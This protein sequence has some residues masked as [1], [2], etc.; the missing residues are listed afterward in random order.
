M[1]FET[2]RLLTLLMGVYTL[3]SVFGALSFQSLPGILRKEGVG[4]DQI[5]L[6]YLLLLPWVLKFL[7]APWLER[8]RKK[9]VTANGQLLRRGNLL[10][11][12]GTIGLAVFRPADHLQL[13]FIAMFV[14]AI[15]AASVDI[16]IDGYATDSL[17]ESQ[18][19]YG[20]MAQIGG[21]YLGS[22]IGG[23]L[24]LILVDQFGWRLSIL[25]LLP[26]I[27]WLVWPLRRVPEV[28]ITL[29]SNEEQPSLRA[30]W[31]R[32]IILG[33][34]T[35][36]FY[37]IGL[38]L[39]FSMLMP[40]FVDRGVALAD[41]GFI[42]AF[43]SSIASLLAVFISGLLVKQ[44]GEYRLMVIMLALQ[45]PVYFACYFSSQSERL[46][47]LTAAALLIA[48]AAV[49]AA[50]FV[51][52]YTAMMRW[53]SG[54]QSGVDFS[55]FQCADV[56]TA[57]LS[58]IAAGWVVSKVGY[59]VLFSLLIGFTLLGLVVIPLLLSKQATKNCGLT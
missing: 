35:V 7:W 14:L 18:R 2:K 48:V 42:V 54:K 43:G 52:L 55:L 17:A 22:I 24:F 23:G 41:I 31:R 46:S 16:V 12:A 13:L 20:N 29:E 58:G 56:T 51:A 15:V 25:I 49:S 4:T 5:G 30:A 27:I 10:I 37:Q 44:F 47:T 11:V 21:G 36:V 19:P 38:R 9:S 34:A 32:P 40:F 3:Q 33:V 39:A 6:I 28:Q 57:M 50:S 26:M 1:H 53:A 45:V 8:A 59:S